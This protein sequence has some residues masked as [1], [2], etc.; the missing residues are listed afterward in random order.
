M[1]IRLT[2]V[3][4][5]MFEDERWRYKLLFQGLI[6]LIPV[7]GVVALLGWTMATCDNLLTGGQDLA[8][9]GLYLRRGSKLLIIGII[10]WIGL[11]V[12]YLVLLDADAAYGHGHGTTFG[13]VAQLY[14]DL[15][16]VLFALLIVPVLVATE[17]RGLIGGINVLH[18]AASIATRPLRSLVALL[19]VAVAVVIGALGFAVIVAAPFTIIYAAAV[20]A[21]VAAWWSAPRRIEQVEPEEPDMGLSDFVIP[22]PFRPPPPES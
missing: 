1:R 3:F 20:I 14:N 19:L 6:L 17:R 15:A 21:S 13:L 12:P 18:V 16:L 9:T 2:E 5:W 4:H 22:I 8:R 7:V 11:G 10:Y